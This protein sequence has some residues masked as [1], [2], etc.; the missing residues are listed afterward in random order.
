MF[1]G[2]CIPIPAD[3]YN[4]ID[5]KR[6]TYGTTTIL[7]DNDTYVQIVDLVS[8]FIPAIQNITGGSLLMMVQLISKTMVNRSRAQGTDPMNV[9]PET[10]L[11]E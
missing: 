3:L 7:Y 9:V 6:W 10:Q 1:P 5:R 8:Q 4:N 11:C 2:H